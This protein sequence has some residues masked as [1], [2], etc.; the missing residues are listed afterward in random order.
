MEEICAGGAILYECLE[1]T[2]EAYHGSVNCYDYVLIAV[3][4]KW[5]R[6]PLTALFFLMWTLK[7]SVEFIIYFKY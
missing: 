3:D 4:V 7:L 1:A 5:V 6:S 2:R